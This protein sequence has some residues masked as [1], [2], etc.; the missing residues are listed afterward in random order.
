MLTPRRLP[1]ATAI[2]TLL[3][4]LPGTPRAEP[5]AA[6]TNPAA[7]GQIAEIKGGFFSAFSQGFKEDFDREVVRGHFDVGTPTNVR[8]YYCMYDPK[9]GKSTPNAVQGDLV[10]RRDGA[11]GIKGAAVTPLSC[12]DAEQKGFLVTTGYLVKGA[13]AAKLTAPAATSAPAPSAPAV[14]AAPAPAPVA[15]SAP[16]APVAPVAAPAPSAST[17]GAVMAVFTSFIAAQNAHDR[18]GV[19]AV[20]L[21]SGEFVWA[22]YGGASV[23]GYKQALDAFEHEWHGVWRLDPQVAEARVTSPGPDVAVLITPLLFTQAA[24]GGSPSMVPI[25]WGGVFVR[26]P[27]GWRIASIF[28]TPF[29]EWRAPGG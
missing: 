22:Q 14:A 12:A 21:D 11:T 13:A 19:G 8:R 17:H 24:P 27:A 3:V 5:A 18:A 28:I 15:A 4:A 25:R 6:V 10:P 29:K 9:K 2:V 16:A 20:L 23:W 1:A 7:E 26:T